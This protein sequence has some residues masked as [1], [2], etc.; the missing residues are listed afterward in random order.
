MIET[1]NNRQDKLDNYFLD[2]QKRIFE[3]ARNTQFSLWNALLSLNAII[4]TVFTGLLSLKDLSNRCLLLS[5]ISIS[6]LSAILILINFIVMKVFY[7]NH[8]EN[9]LNK[10]AQYNQMT[11]TD[12][13]ENHSSKSKDIENTHKFINISE[14]VSICL[15]IIELILIV[16]LVFI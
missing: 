4:I 10:I 12:L 7:F 5:I 1:E 15:V 14:L 3:I 11:E 13:Q 9:Y 2:E 8:S 6:V 16:S